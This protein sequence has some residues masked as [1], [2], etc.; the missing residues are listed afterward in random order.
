M[1][2][3]SSLAEQKA[4]LRKEI[5]MTMSSLDERFMEETSGKIM[6]TVL[7]LREIK[8]AETIALYMSDGNEVR[9]HEL[10]KAIIASGK[11]VCIPAMDGNDIGFRTIKSLNDT[12]KGKFG[13]MEPYAS[14]KNI[15]QEMIDIIIVP[16][17]AFDSQGNRLGRGHGYYD[18]FLKE[19]RKSA[20]CIAYAC[21]H[22]ERVPH[23][24]E[25]QKVD[26][27]VTENMTI[28]TNRKKMIDG[29]G[30]AN[31]IIANH[32]KMIKD[33]GLKA[34]LAV[35]LV[36][37]DPA[38]K[39]YV[40]IKESRLKQVGIDVEV[41]R[42][43]A[44]AGQ[45]E[46]IR[47]I[48]VLNNEKEVNGILVQLP[49]PKHIDTEAILNSVDCMKDVDGLG[50]KRMRMLESGDERLAT[51]TPKGILKMLEA[52]GVKLTGRKIAIIGKGRLVGKPLSLMIKNRRMDFEIVDTKTPNPREITTGADILIT[53]TGVPHLIKAEDIKRGA[54][55]I[56]AGTAKLGDS[57][58]GDVDFDTVVEKASLITPVFGGVGP[59]TI[60]MLVENMVEAAKMQQIRG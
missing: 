46:I 11:N 22:A 58:V 57:I 33:T 20:I 5:A 35:I 12:E 25:D 29:E 32:E 47:K 14:C 31:S 10:I 40:R 39:L 50:E 1:V 16:C 4:S 49:L 56:D 26:I 19:F 51:C 9:T 3:R 60:A 53:A 42:Y 37:E 8:E 7:G 55:V 43:P 34:K 30:I 21:Q 23:N 48:T 28:I 24:L 18:R 38:S 27:I 45:E 6:K 54:V 52:K 41:I 44:D 17:V 59:M 36:G 13:I 15:R 2:H